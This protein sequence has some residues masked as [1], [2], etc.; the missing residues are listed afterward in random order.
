MWAAAFCAAGTERERDACVLLLKKELGHAVA[1]SFREEEDSL[2]RPDSP[3]PI[4]E[5]RV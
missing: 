4:V 5:M 1:S 3:V 2:S